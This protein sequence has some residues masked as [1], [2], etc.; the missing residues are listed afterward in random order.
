MTERLAHRLKTVCRIA[1][2]VGNLAL[3]WIYFTVRE[4]ESAEDLPFTPTQ[5][6]W[7]V[8]L[9]GLLI[10]PALL[11]GAYLS[12]ALGIDVFGL[13]RLARIPE[14]KPFEGLG[15]GE[16]ERLCL[17]WTRGGLG[18][19]TNAGFKLLLT[20]RRLLL[21]S[22]LTSWYL[23]EIPLETIRLLEKQER[24][25]GPPGLRFH[26]LG[27]TDA[28]WDLTLAVPKEQARLEEELAR[29]GLPSTS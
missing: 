4:A 2:L 6:L 14:G 18:R 23:L 15:T 7:L 16:E 12:F 26:L 24:R 27:T 20:S 19:G 17:R 25:F 29:L 22:S 9:V 13:N 10:G 8:L 1:F 28:H 5:G 21:G 3:V 11:L